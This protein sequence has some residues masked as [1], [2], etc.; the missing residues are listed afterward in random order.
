[1]NLSAD[2]KNTNFDFVLARLL[3]KNHSLVH[4]QLSSQIQVF[5]LLASSII[6]VCVQW[7]LPYFSVIAKRGH[8]TLKSFSG[9]FPQDTH[10]AHTD[11][12]YN[13]SDV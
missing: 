9:V 11:T 2:S 7:L 6:R 1:M 13:I 12:Q 5:L 10:H 3:L 4:H 8:C